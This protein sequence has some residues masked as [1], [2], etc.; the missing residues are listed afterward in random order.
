MIGSKFNNMFSSFFYG[1]HKIKSQNSLYYRFLDRVVSISSE[2][3]VVR[4]EK[5]NV[6]AEYSF[7]LFANITM[8]DNGGAMLLSNVDLK[9]ENCFFVNCNAL[10]GGAFYHSSG[11]EIIKNTCFVKCN[12]LAKS[13]GTGRVFYS[14]D[15]TR[16]IT[17]VSMHKCAETSKSGGDSTFFTNYGLS[18]FTN[19]NI[20]DCSGE[21][22]IAG[23][24]FFNPNP[25]NVYSY[26]TV[27]N[28]IDYAALGIVYMPMTFSHINLINNPSLSTCVLYASGTTITLSDSIIWNCIKTSYYPTVFIRVT[29]E[30][31]Y[32]SGIQVLSSITPIPLQFHNC[33]EEKQAKT[34]TR[35]RGIT[36]LHFLLVF[37]IK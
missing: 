37:F 16:T 5:T 23:G 30:Y 18:Q 35:T 20:S 1:C 32:G 9:L 17:Y 25:S 36:N 26:S 2:N 14:Y 6:V 33:Y 21:M 34:S 10:R 19:L 7:C 27:E 29:S 24:E 8:G 12:G 11:T 28:C 15:C 13:D 31:N 22:G 4:V 3:I